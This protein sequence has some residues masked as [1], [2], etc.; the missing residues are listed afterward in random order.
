MIMKYH[1]LLFLLPLVQV[2]LMAQSRITGQ[3]MDANGEGLAGANI[4][5]E[6]T[7]DG[8]SSDQEGF[9]LLESSEI[10]EQVLII[11]FIGFIAYQKTINLE[12]KPLDLSEIILKEE[13]NELTA[14]SITA[15]TFEAGDK[16]KSIA[17]S[18]IDMV[19]TDG[20]SGDVYGA[21]QALPGTTTVGES[22]RHESR[23]RS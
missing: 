10:G 2:G 19:T 3:V 21:L 5:L 14:V 13:I 22:G 17:L 8:A 9:F 16:K 18:S 15:G 23:C 20:S 11:E 4:Y 1:I 12:R 6:G 7:Y